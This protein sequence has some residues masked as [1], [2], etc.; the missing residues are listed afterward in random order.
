MNIK[1]ILA[2]GEKEQALLRSMKAR[3]SA[4]E[5]LADEAAGEVMEQVKARGYEAV[6][7]FSLKYDHTEPYEIT[8]EQ[9][10][11]AYNG[12]SKPLITALEKAAAHIA[13]YQKKLLQRSREWENADGGIVG[14]LVRPMERVGLYVPGGRA[15][16]PSTVL[17]NAIP[18]K[19]AGV[20]ELIM[21]TPPT[22]NL[23]S[24][25][26]AAAKIA[27]IDRVIAVGGMQAVAALTYGAGYIPKVDKLVGP[28]NAYVTAAKRK[29]YG[30]VDIDSLAGPSEILIIADESA[31]PAF[32]AA[33][34]LSQAEHDVLASSILLTTSQ[35]L[36]E[37]VT[38][39]LELQTERL[40]R[41][42]I[43]IR[44]LEDYGA[45]IVCDSLD[46]CVDIA[47]AIAPEHLE[48][49][50]ENP[51][52]ILPSIKNAGAVFLG[53]YAPEP[54]GDYMAGPSHVLPTSGTARFFPPLSAESFLK[55]TSVIEY[56][57]DS[58]R[59]VGEDI[60]AIARSEGL[61]AHANAVRVRI[62]EEEDF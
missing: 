32:V 22:E 11:N 36:A 50:T 28:G 3:A 58:L 16:Y 62:R 27:G 33:D 23:N 25:V 14:Q 21:V 35:S 49:M 47:N 41:K 19:A 7:E 59:L 30:I 39:E 54:L 8:R 42:E 52:E 15:A 9:L 56:H 61:T 45:I 26:L 5:N 51:R 34:L 20:S 12:C 43:I 13:D 2:D 18:A 46:C 31:D 37:A 57:E 38:G 6:K 44:S 10:E 40:E 17:M 29:A 60:I 4:A 53:A 24:A 1:T 48:I 55:K